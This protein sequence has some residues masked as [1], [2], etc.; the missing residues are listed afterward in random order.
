[1]VNLIIPTTLVFMNPLCIPI[2]TFLFKSICFVTTNPLEIL[3]FAAKK[4]SFLVDATPFLEPLEVPKPLLRALLRYVLPRD[5][6]VADFCAGAGQGAT[7][8]NDTG[9]VKAFAFDAS[10]NIKL[11]SKN[12]VDTWPI[13]FWMYI[14]NYI[15]ILYIY[16]LYL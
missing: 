6:L 10:T 12:V 1:M 2:I 13:F 5:S 15:Y 4:W 16:I 8:L 7:F 11:L 9:L 3:I 14:Y